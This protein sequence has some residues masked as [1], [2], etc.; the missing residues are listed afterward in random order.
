MKSVFERSENA[1]QEHTLTLVDPGHVATEQRRERGEEH[2]VDEHD[3]AGEKQQM[4]GVHL[5]RGPR[6]CSSRGR[7]GRRRRS[8]R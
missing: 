7:S 5:P 6:G 3:R 1:R 4:P 8:V 2:R